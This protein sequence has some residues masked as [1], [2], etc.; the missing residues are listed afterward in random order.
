MANADTLE[1][2]SRHDDVRTP[3]S[4]AVSRRGTEDAMRRRSVHPAAAGDDRKARAWQYHDINLDPQR[5]F[6]RRDLAR[7]RRGAKRGLQ[8]SHRRLETRHVRAIAGAGDR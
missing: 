4:S 1:I 6:F 3:I 2:S 8:L 5:R 7:G